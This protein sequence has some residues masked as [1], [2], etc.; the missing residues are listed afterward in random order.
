M[1]DGTCGKIGEKSAYG[2]LSEKS[3]ER[4][5]LRRSRRTWKNNIKTY[6]KETEWEGVDYIRLRYE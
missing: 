2:V 1:M 6:L 3:K 4:I 5:L